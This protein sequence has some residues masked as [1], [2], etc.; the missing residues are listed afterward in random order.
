MQV[1][2]L[3]E[4]PYFVA[5]QAHPCMTSRPVH[6]QPFFVGLVAAARRLAVPQAD[7]PDVVASTAAVLYN[8]NMRP[9]HSHGVIH[10]GRNQP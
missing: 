3:P 9:K 1:L 8:A 10:A 6:P 7:L 5:T 4:H 2:E